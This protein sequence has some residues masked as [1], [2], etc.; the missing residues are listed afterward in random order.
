MWAI[1]GSV[2]RSPDG[3]ALAEVAER[4]LERRVARLEEAPPDV[5]PAEEPN[6]GQKP[7]IDVE[8]EAMLGAVGRVLAGGGV[9]VILDGVAQRLADAIADVLQRLVVPVQKRRAA[10]S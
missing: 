5:R 3:L 6:P 7:A 4:G 2:G 8:F 10:R 9:F 1:V